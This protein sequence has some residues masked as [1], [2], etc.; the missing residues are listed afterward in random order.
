MEVNKKHECNASTC[1]EV[2]RFEQTTNAGST[3]EIRYEYKCA[4][5]GKHVKL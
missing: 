4:H 3:I 5:C 2:K 1:L